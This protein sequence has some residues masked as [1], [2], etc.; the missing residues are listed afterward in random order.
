MREHQE[1]FDT[2]ALDKDPKPVTAEIQQKLDHGK[3]NEIHGMATI[4]AILMPSL[5]PSCMQFVEDGCS[6]IDGE[7]I[8]K[9]LEVLADG[10]IECQKGFHHR[11]CDSNATGGHYKRVIEIK[12]LTD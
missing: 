5:L 9:L 3:I 11:P 1:H 12:C 2:F 6:F 4:C 8:Q 7:V 10:T